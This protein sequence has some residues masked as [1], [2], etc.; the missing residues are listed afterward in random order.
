MIYI[1]KN[2]YNYLP[3]W[4]NKEDLTVHKPSDIMY[5]GLPNIPA[6]KLKNLYK[7]KIE[8]FLYLNESV[9]IDKFIY[10]Y[11]Y[12]AEDKTTYW[13]WSDLLEKL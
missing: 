12:C 8:I 5:H 11:V 2:K 4:K 7:N 13:V 9:Q 3:V 10:L 1:A 6:I